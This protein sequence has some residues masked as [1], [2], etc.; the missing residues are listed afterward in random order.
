MICIIT[1]VM[2]RVRTSRGPGGPS[3]WPSDLGTT[4]AAFFGVWL[5]GIRF[6]EESSSA[7][8]E[9]LHHQV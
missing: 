3:Y 2:R 5:G 1:D 9:V 7:N 8:K 6:C 4:A